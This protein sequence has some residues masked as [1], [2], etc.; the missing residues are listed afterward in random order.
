MSLPGRRSPRTAS[1]TIELIDLVSA[2]SKILPPHVPMAQRP[3]PEYPE[4]VLLEWRPDAEGASILDIGWEAS[5]VDIQIGFSTGHFSLFGPTFD[6]AASDA[7]LDHVLELAE[8]IA[9]G[10]LFSF[11]E[12]NRKTRIETTVFGCQSGPHLYRTHERPK[13]VPEIYRS[14]A[15]W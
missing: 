14:F 12:T 3:D 5:G 4:D 13:G 7:R 1:S 11:S 8:A 6:Q 10:R 15:P 2:L 9:L